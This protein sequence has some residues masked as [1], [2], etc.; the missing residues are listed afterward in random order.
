MT[1]QEFDTKKNSLL[2][3]AKNFLKD[4]KVD[5]ANAKIKE[6]EDLK[7]QYDAESKAAAN[8]AAL[9]GPAPVNQAPQQ[10][11]P[12]QATTG[13]VANVGGEDPT[14]SRE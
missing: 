3:E 10:V 13:S 8:I 9:D 1:K 7:A 12:A 2:A 14:N 6:A 11:A 5:E 4:G